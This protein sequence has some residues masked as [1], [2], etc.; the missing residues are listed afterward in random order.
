VAH[1]SA[2]TY[3][4]T[5]S[6]TGAA[7]NTNGVSGGAISLTKANNGFVNMGN[8][9]G[10]TSGDFS[11][12]A[13]VKTPPDDTTE[14]SEIISKHTTGSPVG[15]LMELNACEGIYPHS[16]KVWLYDSSQAGQEVVSTTSVNDG[17]WHQV[18][19]TYQSGGSKYIY[20]D[21]APAEAGK[22]SVAIVPNAGSFVVGGVTAGGIGE[23][24]FT[25]LID[26]VQ[27]YNYA[28]SAEQVGLLFASPAQEIP[29]HDMPIGWRV[30]ALAGA[31]GS[32]ARDPDLSRYTNGASVTLTA[33][34]NPGFAFAGWSGDTSGTNNPLVLT[35]NSDKNITAS[36]VDIVVPGVTITTPVAGTNTDDMFVLSGNVTDNV[37]VQSARWEWNGQAVGGLSLNSG[38]QFSVAGLR[39]Y[40]GDNHL[41][42]I[43]RDAAGN[44]GSAE[45][46]VTW[47][48]MARAL[49]HWSFNE[50]NGTL[51]V[52]SAGTYNGN[53]SSTGA[54]FDTNGISGGSISL[55][56]SAN[57]YVNMGN[58][59][60]LTTGDYSI[61]AWI[62]MN[63][64]DQTDSSVVLSK[65]QGGSR[66]GY[67]LNVNTTGT[68]LRNDK[69]A[70]IEGGSGAGQLTI[71]ETPISTTSVN[72]GNWHQ[73]VAVYQDGGSK[74]IYV[75]GAPAEDTKPSQA[76][77]PNSAPFLIGGFTAGG[78]T[79]FFTG[80]IDEVQVYNYA[81]TGADVDFLFANPSQVIAE[82]DLPVGWSLNTSVTG[83]GSVQRNPDLARYPNGT[84]ITLTAV[85]NAGFVFGG[86]S[87]DA[88]G[89][90][91]PLNLTM[92]GNKT[93]VANFHDGT[94]PVITITTPT[95]GTNSDERFQ[96]TGTITD[97]RGVGS[98]S[99]TW[100]GQA[101]GPLTLVSN[102][103]LVT[104]L[105]LKL[106][107]NRI[108]VNATDL[109]A[110]A[111]SAEVVVTWA[112]DRTLSIV[113]PGPAQEGLLI[114]VPVLLNSG[115]EVGG[116]SFVMKYDTNYLASPDLAWSGAVGSAL[117][118]VN[119]DVPGEVRATF[120]LPAT[121][122]PAGLQTVATVEFRTRSVPSD[123][124]TD[125]GL[126]LRDVSRPTGDA[127]A[128]GS[129]A[130]SGSA[131]V[132]LRR[133]IGDD[134][135]NDLL[136]VGDATIMLRLLTGLDPVRTW[137]VSGNDVNAN[138]SLDS[139]DVIKVMRAV[140]VLDPQPTPLSATGNHRMLSK[141][142]KR[143]AGGVVGQVALGLDKTRAQAGELVT[144]QIRLEGNTEPLA[145]ASL[146]VDYP[147]NALRLLNAGSTRTGGLVPG[148]A[149]A[150]WN[151]EPGQ[152]NYATQ[153][154]HVSFGAS[155]ANS[156]PT[157]NGVIAELVFEAQAGQTGQYLWPIRVT[158]V[159]GANGYD[160]AV[161]ADQT[162]NYIGRDQIPPTF[163]STVSY[164]GTGGVQMTLSGEIGV[165]YAIETSEDLVNWAPLTTVTGGAGPVT[166][167]D[168]N[169]TSHSHRFYRATAQ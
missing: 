71:Q 53:L 79:G 156:W 139:G 81:L 142:G 77:N 106:G 26:E 64:G 102:Q 137:D 100:N 2:G 95:G 66:N 144:L 134:N 108:R 5:L 167:T 129:Y 159:K 83:S 151:V 67:F 133:V 114:S 9:L 61:V 97:N 141:A 29:E 169:A 63:A 98:A 24:R 65:A 120:A 82:H 150:M 12:V 126:E 166:I 148:T 130:Q 91:N 112:P 78:P 23:S 50:T 42:V 165:N 15:Y 164:S 16:G 73:I 27:V 152:N 14:C 69:A 28:L 149:V 160:P 37:A 110:N 8:V 146:T 31:G 54:A 25:G 49:A 41:K 17:N 59:L 1:D 39:F 157:N 40:Q 85:A 121:A 70:F 30:N 163:G 74:S 103:F 109:D 158:R 96:L 34:A 3:D 58:V 51:A 60:G 19:V 115:G 55:M 38:G 128:S 132:L 131:R 80:L 43:G 101:I 154:G 92:N 57:G 153:N 56:K 127:I 89:T 84:N 46:V 32:V 45:V 76:F 147:T 143:K 107:E 21:G 118:Q 86:W 140:V 111:A 135:A 168:A 119:Y 11:L 116:A 124:T 18:V 4:G 6:S 20:V 155:S 47:R 122:V 161:L 52:D 13:W 162:I 75:D 145:G 62:K 22:P 104:S 68:L 7:F 93:I 105:K 10:L 44:E 36:F 123:L 72:D 35:V 87:G 138:T 125:L 99:W 117:N 94:A 33:T 113:S 90:N 136:D 48:P 88:S